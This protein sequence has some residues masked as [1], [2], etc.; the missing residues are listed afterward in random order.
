MT[1]KTQKKE[2]LVLLDSH[3]ILHRAYH[4]LPA[5]FVSKDGMPTGALYG[6]SAFLIKV[7]KE[8]TPSYIIAAY[9]LPEPTFRHIAY[10][11]YKSH[12]KETV[13][14]LGVQINKSKE[15]LAGFKISVFEFPG[16]EADDILGTISRNKEIKE[17]LKKNLKIIIASGDLDTLQLVEGNKI[18]VYTLKKGINDTTVYNEE[19]VKTRFGFNPK[20]IPDYKGLCGDASD[21]IIGVKGIGEKSAKELIQ[22]F[23]SLD[24]I[25]KTIQKD[26][27]AILKAGI[28]KRILDLLKEQ[29]EEAF[30]SR[31]LAE[32]RD[33]APINFSFSEIKKDGRPNKESAVKIFDE[34]GF[35]SLT[36]RLNEIDYFFTKAAESGAVLVLKKN[37]LSDFKKSAADQNEIFWIFENEK[38]EPA[39]ITVIFPNGGSFKLKEN[40][41]LKE[42]VFFGEILKSKK[43][44]AYKAK[45]LYNYFEKL[46]IEAEFEFDIFIAAWV[47]DSRLNNPTI[48]QIISLAQSE[49]GSPHFADEDREGYGALFHAKEIILKRFKENGQYSL[50]YDI[51]MPLIKVLKAIEDNGVLIDA[52]K[53]KNLSVICDKDLAVIQKK[54]WELAEE[55]FNINSTKELRRVLFQ[56]MKISEKGIR[57]TEGG[58]R[59]TQFKELVKLKDASPII[60]E[61]ISYR[62]LAKLK[63]T[64][65]DTFPLLIKADG[66]IHTS[67]NQTGTVTGRLSSVNPNLQNIPVKGEFGKKIREAFIAQKGCSLVS[68]DYSQIELRVAALLSGDEK[69]REA[70]FENK[71]IHTITAS[72]IF[73]VPLKDVTKEM[74]R[75]AKVIN[76]GI[77]YG[78]GAGALSESL[79][80]TRHEAEAYKQEYFSDFSGVANYIR[81]TIFKAEEMGFTETLYG[82]KRYFSG[83]N[84][85][86]N[87]VYNGAERRGFISN[88]INSYN[89]F[90]RREIERMAVNMPIQGT[91]A[92]IIKIAMVRI[93][94]FLSKNKSLKEKIKMVLQI[95][96]ELLFEIK[97]EF[98]EEACEIIKSI[99][100]NVIP[101][102]NREIPFPVEA[103]IGKYWVK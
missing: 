85:V 34:L 39:G 11:D 45:E 87:E 12:R 100:E 102:E 57:K 7:L 79:G 70:F 26:E 75:K 2:I 4:A 89:D 90:M 19:N 16:F 94:E 101:P 37:I 86:K 67:F 25:Y 44:F 76:F 46:G 52:E 15:I 80:I 96:D 83:M 49:A 36:Q 54:I 66:R 71:D 92:D 10:K 99:M 14:D 48:N 22:K 47:Y 98:L 30:F 35:R 65:I 32:I 63:S 24:S 53:F 3:A 93:H 23:G 51:E 33:D 81:N 50:F 59:S 18:V 28:K 13:D 8:L 58:V 72:E 69:M 68:F 20:L 43:N 40:D 77:L 42:S 31:E 60:R 6:F 55:Q 21:N 73:N 88:G 91:S 41:F 97:D 74:R 82:R 1:G 61:L 84:P 27:T 78:M 103:S 9:D 38:N 95:H 29:K 64:Y 5:T 62:E 56:K 17:L